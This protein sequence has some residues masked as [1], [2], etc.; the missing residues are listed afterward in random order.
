MIE[1]QIL[2]K[3]FLENRPLYNE[4]VIPRIFNKHITTSQT[5]REIEYMCPN[6]ECM[7][8]LHNDDD[9]LIIY[10]FDPSKQNLMTFV[11][12]TCVSCRNFSKSFLVKFEKLEN[13]LLKVTKIGENPQKELPRSKVLS[14]FFKDDKKEYNKAVVCLANG[15]GVAAFAYMRRIVENNI[16]SLLDLIQEDMD[17]DSSLA[18]SLAELKKTSPMSDKIRIAN[19]A[20]P[21]Y[22]KPDGFN[23]LGQIYGLLSDGVHSLTDNECLEK[24]E[25]LQA[26]IEYLISELAA[27]KQNKE[28][29]KKRLASLR[30]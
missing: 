6:C 20:L 9:N 18:L 10:R 4:L 2:L 12:F 17:K 24:A 25:N 8:P 1:E 22:L 19:N 28:D 14:K 21:D 13:D 29:F 23:P 11:A 3:D 30:K 16:N 15:Y 26:C 7:K 5:L 27:H